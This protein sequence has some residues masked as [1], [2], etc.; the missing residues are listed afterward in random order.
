MVA[1]VRQLV[2]I[3]FQVL[4]LQ[5]QYSFDPFQILT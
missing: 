4:V 1:M 3:F 5:T 2:N